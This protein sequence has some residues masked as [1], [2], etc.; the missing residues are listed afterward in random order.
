VDDV[1]S[2]APAPARLIVMAK[3]PVCCPSCRT[4]FQ[5]DAALLGKKARCK[6]CSTHFVLTRLL[7]PGTVASSPWPWLSRTAPA[8]EVVGAGPPGAEAAV[9]EIWQPGDVILDLYEVR[10]VF[11]SG[12]MGL[13]YRVRHRGWN[14]DLA[15][16][17][18]RPEFLHQEQ[19]KEN[20]EREAETWVKLGLHPHTVTCYYVRRLG[21]IPRVFAEYVA[22]GSLA[23]WIKARKLYA[24][25]PRESLPRILAIAIQFAWGLQHAHEQGLVHRDVKPGNVLL[26]GTGVAKVTDFGMAR[27]RGSGTAPVT[28]DGQQSLLVTAGGLTPAFCS[29]EQVRGDLVSRKTDIWSWGVSLLEMFTGAATWSAGYLAPG[30]LEHFLAEEHRDPALPQLTP[31]LIELLRRCFRLEPEDRP[32]DM[33][34]IA[35]ILLDIYRD[36]TGAAYPR[37]TPVSAQALADSLNNR[38]VS[39]LDLKK[40][41]EAEQLW[42][43]ALA[44]DPHHPECT[45]NLGLSRTRAGRMSNEAFLGKLNEVCASHP[46]EWLPLYL[47]GEVHLERGNWPAAREALEKITGAGARLEEVRTAL[48]AARDGLSSV[49]SAVRTYAGHTE[50]VSSVCLSRDG[51]QILSGSADG[52]LRLW[53]TASGECL[54]RLTGHSEWVTAVALAGDGRHALSGSADQTLKWWD[55]VTGKCLRTLGAH[56]KWVLAVTLTADGHHALSGGGDGFLKLWDLASGNELRR[57]SGHFGAVSCLDLSSDGRHV[58]SGGRDSNVKLWDVTTGQCVRTFTGHTERLLAVGLSGDEQLAVSG[59]ADRTVKLWE[60]ATGQCLRTWQGHEGAVHAVA[61]S[62]DGRQALSGSGDRTIRIWRTT[63]DRCLATLEGHGGTV[64]SVCVGPNGRYAVS[65]SS[66]KTL[67]LWSLPRDVRAPF[68]VSRVLPSETALASWADYEQTLVRAAQAVAA[69]DAAGAAQWIRKARAQPGYGRR[70]EAMN[71]WGGLYVRLGRKA[72]NGGWEGATLEGHLDAVTAVCVSG[73]GRFAISG[74]V[75]RTL[76][77]WEVSTGQCVRTLEGHTSA[78]TAVGCTR[79]GRLALS[80]SADDTL[81]LWETTHGRCLCTLEGHEEVIT[82]VALSH[83]A[84]FALSGSGDGTLRFWETTHG[85]CLYTLTGDADP[86]HS[87]ALSHDGRFAA[88]GSGQFLIRNGC[89]RLFTSGQFRLWEIATGRCVHTFSQHSEAVTA[90]CLSVDGAWAITGGGRSALPSASSKTTPTGHLSVWETASGRRVAT[91]A[92]HAD[93]VT[94]VSLSGDRRY[95]L[96]GSTDRTVKLWEIAT[97]QCLRTFAGHTAAVTAVALS[98]D[99]R[100]AISASADRLLKVWVLD[101]ELEDNQPANWDE[102]ARPYLE[103]FLARQTPYVTPPPT[104]PKGTGSGRGNWPF[105]RLFKSSSGAEAASPSLKRRGKPIWSEEDFEELLHIVGCAGYGWLRPEGIRR[106]LERLAAAWE[107]AD[108]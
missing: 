99:G 4:L 55:T 52:S 26:T 71:Q 53:E 61:L 25:G 45:Y 56:E 11:T 75:D 46:G 104:E 94:S 10:E 64:N 65:G 83:D 12:G 101:W 58:L 66:D 2:S 92:E 9:A 72:F 89:E 30:A 3:V 29:P 38:A 33:L 50:W 32:Q 47:L 73:D 105:R 42:E 107:E 62:A 17:C 40:E 22:G 95:V 63:S 6:L 74:S 48:T 108:S 69:N 87:V 93:A 60:V 98:P 41:T 49:Q 80:G 54:R 51:R 102:G 35:G 8:S 67:S 85:R 21:G 16:K 106:L 97:G 14:V 70:P 79:D 81:R 20:F 68:L 91:L 1:A 13:V 31:A 15:V 84:R 77:R 27:A 90:V 82:A 28:G 78:V 37:E 59:S 39:L 34:E 100:C 7:D 86:I 18:S 23:E 44:A 36:T 88:S 103:M 24:G 43:E 19:D 57:F 96:S 5:V 76:K